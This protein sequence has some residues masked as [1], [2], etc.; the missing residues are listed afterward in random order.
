M[1]PPKRVTFVHGLVTCGRSYAD[2]SR[3]NSAMSRLGRMG[4]IL[5]HILEVRSTV[6]IAEAIRTIP[7]ASTCSSN[8]SLTQ[9]HQFYLEYKTGSR[10][11]PPDTRPEGIGTAWM[12]RTICT[13]GGEHAS[14]HAPLTDW[15]LRS[16]SHSRYA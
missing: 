15:W 4:P 7:S 13:P 6:I 12:D 1:P 2:V 10:N 16:I 11:I 5:S 3:Q 14:W 9:I 8:S